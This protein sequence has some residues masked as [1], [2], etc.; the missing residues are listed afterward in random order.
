M[1]VMQ[2]V[3]EGK[4]ELDA[5]VTDYLPEFEMDDERYKNLTVRMLMD[6]TNGLAIGNGIDHYL[7]EDVDSYVHDNIL[8]MIKKAHFKA[9]P[10]E[11]PCYENY[12]FFLLELI[13]EN[14]SGMSYTDYVRENIASKIGAEH[15][16]TAWAL[17]NGDL[18][19]SRAALYSGA[20]PVE[21]PY[22]MA[23]GPGGI[24]ATASDVA[25]FGAAFFTGNDV[26]L[27][28]DAKAQMR[29]RL[30]DDPKAEGCGL[31]WDLV[32]QVRYEKE[33]INVCGKGGDLPYMH[34]FLLVAPD[35]R[36]SCA[37][38]TAGNDS[39]EIA[40]LMAQALM[41]VVLEEQG[42]AV[43]NVAPPEPIM[44]DTV[45]D[46]F[47]KYEGLYCVGGVYATGIC[48][49]TFDSGS[50]YR[51]SIGTGNSAPDRYRHTE[52]GG[53]VKVGDSKKMTSDREIV[54]FEEKDGKVY[55]RTDKV[56]LFP[57][58][59]SKTD[60][61]YSGEKMG[62]NSVPDSVQQSWE[63]LAQTTFV[64]YNEKWSSQSYD[65]P[66]SWLVTDKAF[67]GYVLSNN[68]VGATKVDTIT[69]EHMTD[70]HIEV[71]SRSVSKCFGAFIF[72]TVA[73]KNQ[74]LFLF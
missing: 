43:S 15:T 52:E 66:F 4:V 51:E 29:T 37:V 12:G 60:S 68:S 49:I 69:A 18:G 17:Y 11:Y 14:V 40:G 74:N 7:Y 42:K 34:L 30:S 71:L 65:S 26:L 36:I 38:L 48:T 41:D 53:F 24:Y 6:H 22:E 63:E 10:G 19:D 59:G 9:D 61:M 33:D 39:S 50:M 25:D 28:D 62:E 20:L 3:D 21:Y 54:Y 67:P 70:T 13:T 44:T 32:E 23:A 72:Y 58:L 2:L 57:G 16:G 45:P 56:T 47:K 64:L 1:A 35:E 27:T 31:G 46:S 55:L 73:E 5:P 8:D